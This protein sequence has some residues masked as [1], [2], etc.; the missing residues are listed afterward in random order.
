MAN[1]LFKCAGGRRVRK[2]ALLL[3]AMAMVMPGFWVSMTMGEAR[4]ANCFTVVTQAYE[5]RYKPAGSACSDVNVNKVRKIPWHS[6]SVT[7]WGEY[8]NSSGAFVESK[9]G[10]RKY[11]KGSS[12]AQWPAIK[13][14]LP[15]SAYRMRGT[16]AVEFVLRV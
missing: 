12:Y 10:K 9:Q 5:T 2:V 16:H 7:I 1:D 8:K 15:G 14:L 6:N 13:T 11:V 4:A 3:L